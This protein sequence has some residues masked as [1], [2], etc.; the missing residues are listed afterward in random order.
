MSRWLWP[1]L[2][3]FLPTLTLAE[4]RVF[5]I[6]EISSEG[7]MVREWPSRLDP[8]QL[9]PFH[10]LPLGHR[11]TYVQTWLCRGDTSHQPLCPAPSPPLEPQAP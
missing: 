2:I 11:L 3:F 1:C 8:E 7:E 10:T 9:R 4:Y 6:Q 5:L